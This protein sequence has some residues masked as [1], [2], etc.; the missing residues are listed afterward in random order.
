MPES[1]EGATELEDGIGETARRRE[2]TM[3]AGGIRDGKEEVADVGGQSDTSGEV[4][5]RGISA[6]SSVEEYS[7]VGTSE[8][9]KSR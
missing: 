3:G 7:S 4:V 8:G 1:D 6:M 2:Y 5:G 9:N